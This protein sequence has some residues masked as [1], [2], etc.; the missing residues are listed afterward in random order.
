M[1]TRDK[2]FIIPNIVEEQRMF[3]WAGI[4][5]GEDTSVKLSKAIKRLAIL[6]GASQLRF[7]GKIYGTQKDYWIV[8]G[9]LDNQ[10]ED[11]QSSD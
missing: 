5:F 1:L 9:S 7:W 6:S 8:E 10:E 11:K 3:E 2:T 4:V